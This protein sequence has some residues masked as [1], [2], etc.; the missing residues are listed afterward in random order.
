MAAKLDYYSNGKWV[1]SAKR[2]NDLNPSDDTVWA[3]VADADLNAIEDAID[4]AHAAFPAWA[5]LAYTERAHFMIAMADE[6]K[7]RHTDIVDALQAEAGGWFGK[8]L[9]EAGYVPEVFHAAAASNYA[10]IGEVMPSEYHKL[11]IAMRRPIGVVTVISPW[12][13]P[14]LLT[15]RGLAFPMAAGNTVVLKPS[16]ETPFTGGVLFAEIAEA[17][18]LPAGVLNVVT[19]SRDN[20]QSVGNELIENPLVKG[21][22]FTGS[23]AV[24]RQIAAKAGAHLKKACIELGGKD[25]LIIC[26]DADTERAL[27]A[28]N[29]GS[30]MHQGQVCMSVEKVL[31]QDTIYEKFLP[32]FVKRA[33]ALQVG[34]PTAEKSN[35]IGPLINDKQVA[36]VKAQL[37]DAIAK[38]AR[39]EVGGNI[40][41]RFVE[42]TIL[43]GVTTDML[44]YQNETFGP[45]VP[46]IPFTTDE[47]AIA[48][49]NDTEYGLSSGVIT[50]NE[51]RGFA[52][53][54]ALETG[55]CHINC[56]SINDEPHIP[57]GGSKASGVG[58]H[59]GRW[60][61]ETFTETRWITMDRGGRPYPPVF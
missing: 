58:R 1:A 48:I 52:I 45:V 16:E 28:A 26:D 4:A 8:G 19:C 2:F 47:H 22:S 36:Q 54:A 9:F 15:S 13:F 44:I 38:G 61:T 6:I 12:N 59:G 25:A 53:A 40:H 34:D 60:S 3:E 10:P 21:I 7:R 37:D 27:G 17:V 50:R 41:G 33:A 31:V 46:V 30:F 51:Q 24:G 57:F 29:F 49:A 43:T 35:V 42:P 18:G 56:S 55:M 14:A 32:A 20:V 11:S 23:T 5:A 39:V